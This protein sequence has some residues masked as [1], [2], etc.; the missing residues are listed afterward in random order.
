[1]RVISPKSET[2]T[3]QVNA[4]PLPNL[5]VPSAFFASSRLC[6]SNPIGVGPWSNIPRDGALAGGVA[7]C[8]AG[9]RRQV[10]SVAGKPRFH[11]RMP[12][13]QAVHSDA[14]RNMPWSVTNASGARPLKPRYANEESL[15][16]ESQDIIHVAAALVLVAKEFITFDAR[17]GALAKRVGL[18]VRP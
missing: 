8:S 18:T 5:P 2:P 16:A 6:C 15:L 17:Q 14:D 10:T 13:A 1:M 3:S 7:G 4:K 11:R 9:S 12:Q